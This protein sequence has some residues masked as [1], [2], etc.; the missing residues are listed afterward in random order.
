MGKDQEG[1]EI[2]VP[3]APRR[4]MSSRGEGADGRALSRLTAARLGGHHSS[5]CVASVHVM[6]LLS[7]AWREGRH[8]YRYR[9]PTNTDTT[10]TEIPTATYCQ[11][12]HGLAR[13]GRCDGRDL[14]RRQ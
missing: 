11:R 9:H 13:G 1:A 7:S 3:A 14:L 5:P 10:G 6:V 4:R 12:E 8:R 2:R